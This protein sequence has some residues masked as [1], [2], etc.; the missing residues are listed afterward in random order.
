MLLTSLALL[1]FPTVLEIV[2]DVNEWKRDIR[3]KK[4]QDVIIRGIVMILVALLNF[5]FVDKGASF[6]ASFAVS[7]GIFVMFFDYFMGMYL[8]KN[9]FFLGTTSQSDRF[10]KIWPW[11]LT[12]LARGTVLAIAITLY[13]LL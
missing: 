11:Y 10:L 5:L 8:T 6:W 1:A 4:G 12:L 13:K 2:A 9:P 7:V 3:D